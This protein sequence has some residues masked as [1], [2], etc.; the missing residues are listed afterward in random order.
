MNLKADIFQ[1]TGLY[2]GL[3]RYKLSLAVAFS[4]AT[5]YIISRE[6][7]D[8]GLLIITAG[9]FLLASGS[10]ALNQ[11]TERIPDAVMERTRERPLPSGKLTIGKAVRAIFIL[12]L[13]GSLLLAS[14]N[15]YAFLLGLSCLFLYNFLYTFLKSRS[16]LAIVPGALVG[17]IP[18]LM[19]FIAAGGNLSDPRI[20]SFSA[21]MLMWQLPHFWI[22]LLHYHDDYDRAGFMTISRYLNDRQIRWLVLGWVLITSVFLIVFFGISDIFGKYVARIVWILNPLFIILFIKTLFTRERYPGNKVNFIILNSFG[23]LLMISLIIDA[24]LH[25]N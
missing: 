21:F 2:A 15:I 23:A 8:L 22:V 25:G 12:L 1:Y 17:A 9:V 14:S 16:V 20:L 19:G 10:A 3:A 11:V 4:A 6:K 13:A 24:L 7:V 5:G 18:P